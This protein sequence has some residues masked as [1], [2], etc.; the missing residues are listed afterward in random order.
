MNITKHRFTNIENKLVV[1]RGER[2]GGWGKIGV[3]DQEIQ[4]TM[5]KINKLQGYIV[6]H[7][8]Y[9]QYFIITF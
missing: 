7:R 6:H 5:Y 9:S 3:G 4:T 2:E 8:E 1:T